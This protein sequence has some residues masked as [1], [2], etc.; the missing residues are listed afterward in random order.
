MT[1]PLEHLHSMTTGCRGFRGPGGTCNVG[2]RYSEPEVRGDRCVLGGRGRP[3]PACSPRKDAC[4]THHPD[5]RREVRQKLPRE[6]GATHIVA[7]REAA[8]TGIAC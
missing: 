7:G 6:F 4:G 2:R 5:E 1:G 8:R 3:A